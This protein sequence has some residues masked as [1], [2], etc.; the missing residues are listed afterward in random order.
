[1]IGLIEVVTRKQKA[2]GQKTLY[3]GGLVARG[4]EEKEASQSDSPTKLHESIKLLFL[5]AVNQC[6]KLRSIYF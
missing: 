4:V 5:I 2:N 1:M 6:F 3:K